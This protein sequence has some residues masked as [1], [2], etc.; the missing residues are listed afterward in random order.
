VKAV[1]TRISFE[2]QFPER[3]SENPDVNIAQVYLI[4]INAEGIF[5]DE[6][7]RWWAFVPEKLVELQENE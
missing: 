4:S 2:V 3:Y 1:D 6:H 7:H 5:G